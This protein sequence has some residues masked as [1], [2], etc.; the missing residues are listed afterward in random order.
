MLGVAALKISAVVLAASKVETE[1][2]VSS[3]VVTV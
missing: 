2:E 3:W 1:M